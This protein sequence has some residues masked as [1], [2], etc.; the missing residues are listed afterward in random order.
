MPGLH[1]LRP[2]RV[3]HDPL[4]PP[5]QGSQPRVLQP[6][7]DRVHAPGLARHQ[8]QVQPRRF[9]HP[10]LHLIQTPPLEDPQPKHREE[11][12]RRRNLRVLP[13]IVVTLD[14]LPEPV[15]LRDVPQEP[16]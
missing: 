10:P 9:R 1:T 12:L 4:Q 16:S 2:L 5:P 6:V 3:L 14:E 7:R 11:D 13:V 8:L 15:Y